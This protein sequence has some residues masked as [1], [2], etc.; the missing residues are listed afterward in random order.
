MNQVAI[1][2]FL[3]LALFGVFLIV[4]S[5]TLLCWLP[6]ADGAVCTALS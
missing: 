6:G 1:L 3:V 4:I 2:Y 5:I